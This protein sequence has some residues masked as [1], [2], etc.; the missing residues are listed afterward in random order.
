MLENLYLCRWN[1]RRGNEPFARK[2]GLFAYDER[3]KRRKVV[4]CA[5]LLNGPKQIADPRPQGAS[6]PSNNIVGQD[7]ATRR[8]EGQ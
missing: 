7:L 2:T 1:V 6:E 8:R 4:L 5:V 3:S